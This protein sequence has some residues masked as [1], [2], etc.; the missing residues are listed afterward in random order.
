MKS[1]PLFDNLKTKL[2]RVFL[3]IYATIYAIILLLGIYS[4]FKISNLT[5]TILLFIVIFIL[6]V[7]PIIYLY[8]LEK[9]LDPI[10]HIN[11]YIKNLSTFRYYKKK[12]YTNINEYRLILDNIYTLSNLLE[13]TKLNYEQYKNRINDLNSKK[14]IIEL[15]ERDLIY[16]ISHELKTPLS[17]I[18][19][20]ACAILDGIYEGEDAINEL[21][22]IVNQ[23][24]IS[25]SMIQDVLNVFKLERSDFKL[26]N[27]IFNLK[28]LT[29]EKLKAFDELFKKYKSNLILN[30]SDAN[31]YADKKQIGTVLSNVINNAITNSPIESDII[32]NVK[33]RGNEAIFDI[34]NT[35]VSIPEEKL[36]HIFEPFVKIDESHT[37]KD[38]KGNGLGLYIVKQIMNKYNYD[39]GIINV[40][41]GVKFFFVGTNK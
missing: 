29:L 27:E 6:T 39:F 30:L 4:A 34:T 13:E 10:N 9:V 18:E 14:E 16:S 31:I 37:K 25:V 36:N 35:N 5:Y 17:I 8:Y 38:H 33:A 40:E 41:N 2:F 7:I 21:N 3:I 28:D 11:E 20:G 22:E 12:E 32:I 15:Q 24:K 1:K 26:N 19:A 23:C